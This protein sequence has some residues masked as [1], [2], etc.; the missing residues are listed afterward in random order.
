MTTT[1]EATRRMTGRQGDADF[2]RF[3]EYDAL[4]PEA[5]VEVL[6]GRIYGAVFRGVIDEGA[7]QEVLRKFW[8][9][10]A[11]KSRSGEVCESQGSYVGAYHYHKPTAQYL[12]E[13][14]E[15]RGYLDSV[16]DVPNEPSKM[17]RDALGAR[18]AEEG[19]TFRIS[20]QDGREGCPLLIR[21]WNAPGE[22]ALQPHDDGSQLRHPAQSGFEI[23]RTPAYTVAAVN[24]CLENGEGGRLVAWNIDPDEESKTALGLELSGSPYPVEALEGFETIKLD[25]R[26]GDIYVFD[27]AF[28]HG[29]DATVGDAKRTTMAWNMGFCD[30]RTVVSWT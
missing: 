9:S 26:Q 4:V 28:V 13:A 22:F 1:P 27:G 11:R 14:A 3:A 29:V 8:E 5:V 18:L 7:R 10:P 16:L 20:Q 30:D 15:I 19:V 12:D 6:R 21:H 24:M 17:F 2:F 23:Q 25:V